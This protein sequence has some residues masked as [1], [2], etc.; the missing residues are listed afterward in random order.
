[1]GQARIICDITAGHWKLDLSPACKG[2]IHFKQE[3]HHLFRGGF[4]TEELDQVLGT[5]KGVGGH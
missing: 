4:L 5:P 2:R 1:M 3:A